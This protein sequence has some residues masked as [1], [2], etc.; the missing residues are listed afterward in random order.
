VLL[1]E[2]SMSPLDKGVSLSPWVARVVD[3]VDRSGLPY[4]LGPMGTC[5]EGEWSEVMALLAAC[6]ER[7]AEDCDR[8]TVSLKGDWRRGG[9]GR[10]DGKV[11]KVEAVLGRPL[12]R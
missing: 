4:R 2:F 1:A 11:A 10:I 5:V 8:I 9:A 7:M 12:K 6:F 3:V